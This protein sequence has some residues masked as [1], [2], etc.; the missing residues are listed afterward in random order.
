MKTLFVNTFMSALPTHSDR[1]GRSKT[2]KDISTAEAEVDSG[3]RWVSK[4]HK[5]HTKNEIGSFFAN[6]AIE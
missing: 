3:M 2:M 1:I 6:I 5:F 4:D